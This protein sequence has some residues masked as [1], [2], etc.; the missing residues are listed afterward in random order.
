LEK[1]ALLLALALL[2]SAGIVVLANL[3]TDLVLGR[4][5]LDD[6]TLG[7]IDAPDVAVLDLIFTGFPFYVLAALG[8]SRPV[9][10]VVGVVLTIA[11]WA[12]AVWQ[13][14][15]DSLTGFAGGADIGLGLIMIAAPFVILSILLGLRS[16]LRAPTDE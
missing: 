6:G 2:L 15:R 11:S 5:P 10:W 16:T 12:Y 13:V 1:R 14:W 3:A 9:L 4:K 8:E 7:F